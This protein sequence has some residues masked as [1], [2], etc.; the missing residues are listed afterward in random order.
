[1]RNGSSQKLEVLS[2][3]FPKTKNQKL[4]KEKREIDSCV[5]NLVV[6]FDWIEM[7]RE[8]KIEN[9]Q[10]FESQLTENSPNYF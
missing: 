7:T 2:K 6:K 9:S 3:Y 10:L 8:K 1:M 5:N 4:F